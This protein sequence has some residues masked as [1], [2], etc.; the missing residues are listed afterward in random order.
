[1]TSV[2]EK[3]A[4]EYRIVLAQN[5]TCHFVAKLQKGDAVVCKLGEARAMHVYNSFRK[6]LPIGPNSFAS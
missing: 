6:G 1:M 2:L 4:G 5:G 3:I